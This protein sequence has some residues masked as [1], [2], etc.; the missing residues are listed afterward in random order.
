MK[1]KLTIDYQGKILSPYIENLKRKYIDE[2]N[3]SSRQ[4]H[5]HVN[6]SHTPCITY[7]I[8][9]DIILELRDRKDWDV[10]YLSS[11]SNNYSYSE[12]VKLKFDKGYKLPMRHPSSSSYIT[13]LSEPIKPGEHVIGICLNEPC[14]I[15]E[16]LDE[17]IG[18]HWFLAA[19]F[20]TIILI[21][22]LHRYLHK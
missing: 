3:E 18:F 9:S 13:C 14:F 7:H 22:I 11:I 16:T 19:I 20:G 2:S 15:Q 6:D 8:L 12:K 21:I 4:I 5:I 10:F 1:P 17:M